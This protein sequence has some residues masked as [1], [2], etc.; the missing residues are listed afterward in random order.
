[1][2]ITMSVT[3]PKPVVVMVVNTMSIAPGGIA[4]T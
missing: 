1:M 3:A 4:K 2:L